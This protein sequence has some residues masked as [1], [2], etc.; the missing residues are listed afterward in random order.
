MISWSGKKQLSYGSVF[1]AILL[2]IFGVPTYFALKTEPTCFDK[3]QNQ[4]ESGIDCGGICQ[5]ACVNQVVGQPIISWSRSFRVTNGY[6]N[7][8]AYIQNPN[9]DYVSKRVA[10]RFKVYDQDNVI[11]GVREGTTIVSPTKNILIFEPGFQTGELIPTRVF[12]EFR[13]QVEWDRY[14][15]RR[16]EFKVT[17]VQLLTASTSPKIVAKIQNQSIETFRDLEVSVVI[18]DKENNAQRTSR[19]SI[20]SIFDGE[21]K[22]V[23]FTWPTAIDF[24]ISKI[25]VL[26]KLP[27]N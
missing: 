18:Y 17:D 21:T 3:K 9:V 5:R 11:L 13:N 7:L 26:P 23:I 19:T 4:D 14:E 20:S 25:E 10:Y 15:Q 12:F 24:E 22:E 1:V 27:I 16:P 2:V 6:Y 8:A